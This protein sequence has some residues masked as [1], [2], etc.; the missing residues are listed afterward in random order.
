MEVTKE[1]VENETFTTVSR[2]NKKTKSSNPTVV[3]PCVKED[4]N[5]KQL[6]RPGKLFRLNY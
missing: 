6:P 2:R 4:L 5:G 3:A 1:D